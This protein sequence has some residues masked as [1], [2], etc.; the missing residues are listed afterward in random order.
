MTTF[1]LRTGRLQWLDPVHVLLDATAGTTAP[2]CADFVIIRLDMRTCR[3]A[4]VV[5][6]H[7]RPA[8]C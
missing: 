7:L 4:V 3:A 2:L 6:M 1:G 8:A 5:A